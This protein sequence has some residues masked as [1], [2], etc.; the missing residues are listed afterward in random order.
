M[1]NLNVKCSEWFGISLNTHLLILTIT[2]NGNIKVTSKGE[3][4]T[5]ELYKVVDFFPDVPLRAVRFS[6]NGKYMTVSGVGVEKTKEIETFNL[7]DEND[8]VLKERIPE[9]DFV[10]RS[11]DPNSFASTLVETCRKHGGFGLAANQCGFK[12]RVFVM[13]TGD[14]FI[15][16]FNPT[17]IAE[18][19]E[20]SIVAEGCLSFPMLALKISRPASIQVEYYDWNGEKH[21]ATFEGLTSHIFQHE[22]DHLNG[23]CYTER[24]KPMA[25]KMGLKKRGKF[26]KLVERYETAQKKLNKII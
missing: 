11:V 6:D 3:S 5:Y 9:F 24:S 10:N 4:K 21:E 15:A 1:T 20:K 12:Q 18:T 22:L 13:G 14:D 2:D 19:L 7:V 8:P 25:L 17:I 26:H 16:C 23:I